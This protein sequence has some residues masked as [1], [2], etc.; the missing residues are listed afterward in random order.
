MRE[1]GPL[2]QIHV[3]DEDP[4]PGR[5]SARVDGS[6]P[7]A[8]ASGRPQ[9]AASGGTA[10]PLWRSFN[11]GNAAVT[12]LV[13]LLIDHSAVLSRGFIAP[14]LCVIALQLGLDCHGLGSAWLS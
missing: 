2:N 9:R 4:S 8:N 12:P 10:P 7:V 13:I 5:S 1:G 14:Q 11:V 3:E 6:M